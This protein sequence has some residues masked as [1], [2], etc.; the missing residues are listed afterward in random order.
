MNIIQKPVPNFAQGRNGFKPE[1]IVIH[2]G[3]A[4][5]NIIYQ[6]F[7]TEE[8]SSHY[9]VS[10]TG[11]VWQFVQESDCAW[12]EGVVINP[13]AK[14]V[15]QTHHGIN[16]NLYCIGIEHEG[17]PTTDFTEA[18]YATTSALV[19]DIAKRYNIPLDRTHILRHN[20]IQTQKTCPG[21]A[22]VDRI[23]QMAIAI[24][25]PPAPPVIPV[26]ICK[27][28]IDAAVKSANNGLIQKIIAFLQSLIQK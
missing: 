5:Q 4:S 28:Q 15:T 7:L 24:N 16:P 19:A 8:K 21:I 23:V 25:T 13:T 26:D 10:Y 27:P 18:Q 14:I 11:E 6:T 1:A 12:T 3:E 9:C 20:E 17:F 22:N 2:I